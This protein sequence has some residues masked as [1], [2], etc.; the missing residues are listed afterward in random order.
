MLW[1]RELVNR[2][3]F[4]KIPN[5]GE[6]IYCL[7]RRH[8]LELLVQHGRLS[9]IHSQMEDEL[10]MNAEADCAGAVIRGQHMKFGFLQHSLMTSR[11]HFMLEMAS[12]SA[13][14][15]VELTAWRQ[16]AELRGN[17]AHVPELR[18]RRTDGTNEYAW[19][20]CDETIRLSVEPDAMF[21]L[22]VRARHA[23]EQ[24][25]HFCYEADRGSMPMADMLEK[26]RAYYHFIKRQQKHKDAFD[27][28]PIRAVLV[29]TTSEARA[30][31]LMEL[32]QHPAV[33]GASKRSGLFWF[34]I[35]PLFADPVV[36]D[37][38][39]RVLPAYI[40]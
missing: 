15:R 25:L 4:P 32:A 34:T 18:S 24:S 30:R 11:M 16:S 7:D 37:S 9:E 10:R 29:E 8:S 1:E 5:H 33:V 40:G 19:E 12:R 39:N 17:K 14:G 38:A 3:A 20:E 23:E 21:S 6:F 2:F 26:F 27:M 28:Y 31:K 36:S 13:K 22:R 35:S